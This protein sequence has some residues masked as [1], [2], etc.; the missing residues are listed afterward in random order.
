MSASSNG[1][2]ESNAPGAAMEPEINPKMAQKLRERRTRWEWN[3]RLLLVSVGVSVALLAVSTASYLYHS[4]KTETTFMSRADLAASEKDFAEEARWLRRYSLLRPGSTDVIVRMAVAADTAADVALV[5]GGVSEVYKARKQL[6]ESIALLGTEHPEKVTDLRKRLIKRLLQLGTYGEAERNVIALKASEQDPKATDWLAQ[7]LLGQVTR[8]SYKTREPDV[9]PDDYWYWLSR[10]PVGEVL[11]RSLEQAPSLDA[12]ARFLEA[13][14]NRSEVFGFDQDSDEAL[15]KRIEKG[16]DLCVTTLRSNPDSRSKLILYRFESVPGDGEEKADDLLLNAAAVASVQLSETELSEDDDLPQTELPDYYWDYVILGEAAG[17]MSAQ[18]PELADSW[19][20]QLLDFN[21]KSI[22]RDTRA[23]VFANAGLFRQSAGLVDQ[24]IKT[25]ERGLEVADPNNLDLLGMIANAR[26]QQSISEESDDP[27]LGEAVKQFRAAVE[28]SEHTLNRLT[29]TQ[30]TAEQRTRLTIRN[31]VAKWRLIRVEAF[32][33][34][35][36]REKMLA[37]SRLTEA[38]ESPVNI[39]PRE[40]VLV[41]RQLASLHGSEGAW[42]RASSALERAITYAP[43]DRLL[44]AEAAEAFTRSGNRRK[45]VEQWRVAGTSDALALQIRSIEALFNYEL[46]LAPEQRDFSSLRAAV[47]TARER[48]SATPVPTDETGI[49]VRRGALGRL[50]IIDASLP[51]RGVLLEDYL[52]SEVMGEKVAKLADEYVEDETIQA[53]AAERLAAIGLAEQSQEAVDRLQKLVGDTATTFV[54]AKARIDADQGDLLGAAKNLIAQAKRDETVAR[55]L[56]LRA[57]N[58]A[59]QA[60]DPELAY[61]ALDQIPKEQHTLGSLFATATA[62]KRIPAD[63]PL[64]NVNGKSIS[65]SDL[66]DQWKKRLGDREHIETEGDSAQAVDSRV[67]ESYLTF[68]KASDLIDELRRDPNQIERN[69]PR[70]RPARRLVERIVNTRPTWGEAISLKGW[71]AALTGNQDE[72]IRQLQRGIAAGDRRMQ[73]RFQL[74]EQLK[75]AGRYE[76]AAREIRLTSFATETDLSQFA[77]LRIELAQKAGDYK[78]SLKVAEDVIADRPN[79]FMPQVLL[80]NT[81]TIAAASAKE[82]Q[83]RE[84]L[85][86]LADSAIQKAA[87]LSD[88]DEAAVLD[89]RLRMRLVEGDEKKIRAEIDRIADSTLDEYDKCVFR[90]RAAMAVK[91]PDQALQF[92]IR[93][94]ALKPSTATK[95]ALAQLYGQLQRPD[96]RIKLLRDALRLSNNNSSIRNDLATSLVTRDGKEADW[97][98]IN[99]LLS[100]GDA[101]TPGNRLLFAALLSQRGNESQKDQ[102]KKILR[103]LHKE[104]NSRSDDAARVL[105]VLLIQQLKDTDED[106]KHTQA[107]KRLDLEIRSLYEELTQRAEPNVIDLYRYASHLLEQGDREKAKITQLEKRMQ[108]VKS[109]TGMEAGLDVTIQLAQNAGN[110]DAVPEIIRAW[111]EDVVQS[112]ILNNS[113]ASTAAGKSLLR[114]GFHEQGMEWFEKAYQDDENTLV[115]YIVYLSRVGEFEK[116]VEVSSDHFQ[117]HGDALSAALMVEALMNDMSKLPDHEKTIS[118]ALHEHGENAGL[119]DAVGTLRL[120]QG[121]YDD[122][123]AMYEQALKRDPNRIRSL[124]NLAMALSETPSR[125]KEAIKPINLAIALGHENPELLDTK[126]V[127]LLRMDNPSEAEIVFRK[128]I[129]A[130]EDSRYRFHLIVA[131]LG[132]GKK[133]DARSEWKELDIDSLDSSTLTPSER[134]QLEQMK[135]D[136]AHE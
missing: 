24:A 18:N 118:H 32:L 80:A 126:G 87:E 95:L 78:Q 132:Q 13:K 73:T 4:S 1:N 110:A 14:K 117:E 106:E 17:R 79:D 115:Q 114:H 44:R 107:R 105:C 40:R 45:A 82:N 49:A 21:P 27:Q 129:A 127:V 112:G 50:A 116:A 10:Q 70:L 6:G 92:L 54:L 57:A 101:I 23:N 108:Q 67:S 7:A 62:A 66:V 51:T 130:S 37:I 56:L 28:A 133:A 43:G 3:G 120:M 29:D 89:A 68:L 98:E 63:S 93:A 104:G 123:V 86:E 25:W 84:E 131:L 2:P 85:L 12:I 59:A 35:Q 30:I 134:K 97:G 136:F 124:N 103:E 100:A 61:Q 52:L 102:A 72:A 119:M 65:A 71:L 47:R 46:R 20:S 109:R 38:L 64:L 16:V 74:W 5:R 11:I 8:G 94:D 42:D 39:D 33:H 76:E 99:R 48:I 31:G 135:Q 113:E 88:K 81:A 91:E 58:Y 111:T 96:D 36:N 9:S 60:N 90:S 15:R 125:A 69:D 19:F 26:V 121:R 22:P 77:G 128:A 122:S 55:D 41:A 34:L 53:F 83:R 75:R